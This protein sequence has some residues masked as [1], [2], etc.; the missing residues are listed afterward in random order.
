[1]G[2]YRENKRPPALKAKQIEQLVK[3][4]LFQKNTC[5]SKI[6]LQGRRS[7]QQTSLKNKKYIVTVLELSERPVYIARYFV[8][9]KSSFN[10]P[11]RHDSW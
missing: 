6:S 5:K 11:L 1:M 8:H 4:N 9:E 3:Q 7:A 2:H 10:D